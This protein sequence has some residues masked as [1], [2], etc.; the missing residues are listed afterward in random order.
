MLLPLI[1]VGCLFP[2]APLLG[3]DAP[4]PARGRDSIQFRNGDVL[5]GKLQSITATNG[6][7][8]EHPDAEQ[9]IQ[10]AIE[11]IAEIKLPPEAGDANTNTPAPSVSYCQVKL[12]N[13]DQLEGKLLACDE[14]K[15]V[16]STWYGGTLEFPRNT[17]QMIRPFKNR[18][19]IFEGPTG[20]EGWTIGK[21]NLAGAA[22]L[23]AGVWRFR[24]NA[25]Y[26]TRSASIARDLKLPDVASIQFDLLWKGFFHLAIALYTDYLQPVNLATKET[27]PDFGG[28]YSLQLNTFYANLLPIKRLDP[29]RYL[30]QVPLQM[31]SAKNSAHIEIRASKPKPGRTRPDTGRPDTNGLV[32]LFIDGVLIK[33]WID[34][35]GFAGTGTGFR[36]VHQ[37]QGG[38]RVN[39][40]RVVEWDGQYEDGYSLPANF[41]QDLARLRNGDRVAGKVVRIQDDKATVTQGASSIE[42]PLERVKQLEFSPVG[43]NELTEGPVRAY[44]GI[45]GSLSFQLER[46]DPNGITVT[47]PAFGKA[48]LKPAAFE[49]LRFGPGPP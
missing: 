5:Y 22:G 16:L 20:L 31:L 7:A 3:I 35:E 29:L 9:S 1:L 30:G 34:P 39:N 6:V 37:G 49:R 36:L 24:N 41:Q 17:V 4:P 44:F 46:L 23:E 2:V 11:Q 43:K 14:H 32:T 45:G 19:P 18:T 47:S 40:L 48:T 27:E 33:E 10:F 13:Q 12:F 8:W 28:F 26:A 21:V 15:L 38:I 42:I 25:F